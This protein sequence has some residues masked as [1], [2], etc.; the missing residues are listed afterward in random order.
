MSEQR[1]DERRPLNRPGRI[2]TE[3]ESQTWVCLIRDISSAGAKLS[4]N[5]A[6]QIPGGFVLT[7]PGT[8]VSPR[9]CLVRWRS[10]RQLGVE[11]VSRLVADEEKFILDELAC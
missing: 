6:E 2:Y 9:R 5:E 7:I 3:D 10:E 11:F 4:V 8:T 1:H